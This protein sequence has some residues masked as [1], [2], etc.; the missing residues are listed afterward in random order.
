MIT[1]HMKHIIPSARNPRLY[2]QTINISQHALPPP[3]HGPTTNSAP[4]VRH[5]YFVRR[6][7]RGSLP[8]YTDI[9]NGGTRYHVQIRNVEGRIDALT[10]ELKQSLFESNSPEA[11]RLTVKVQ[12]QR[13][14]TIT[15]GRFK[16][17]VAI[18]LTE[19]GF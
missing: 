18:W 12:A 13:H 9:R 16:R 3:S 10:A 4:A 8:V 19:R 6:N 11:S 1:T 17:A 7:S 15:G 5:S 2:S 14:I